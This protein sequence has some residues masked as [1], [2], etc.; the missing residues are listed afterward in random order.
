MGGRKCVRSASC[1]HWR[2]TCPGPTPCVAVLP[3]RQWRCRRSRDCNRLLSTAFADDIHPPNPAHWHRGLAYTFKVEHRD[4][5]HVPFRKGGLDYTLE[6]GN[7][8]PQGLGD[9]PE[10]MPQGRFWTLAFAG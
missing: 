7:P 6:R 2:L 5:P 10:V 8:G 9:R 4:S 3:R 1:R